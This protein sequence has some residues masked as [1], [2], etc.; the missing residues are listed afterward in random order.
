M[1]RVVL[2]TG[3]S[4][5]LGERFAHLLSTE[6]GVDRVIGVDVGLPQAGLG[7]FDYVRVDLRSPSGRRRGAR[8]GRLS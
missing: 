5:H 8:V 2:V 3:V 4:D 7:G 1:G 6:D